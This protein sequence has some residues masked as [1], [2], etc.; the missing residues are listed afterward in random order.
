VKKLP[1]LHTIGAWQ[2]TKTLNKVG[3]SRK[4]N[5]IEPIIRSMVLKW[6]I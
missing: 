4:E 1:K 5:I 6:R 2:K 3:T